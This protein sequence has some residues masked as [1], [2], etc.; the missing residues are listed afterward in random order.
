MIAHTKIRVASVQF[1]LRHTPE[2]QHFFDR[3][4]HFVRAAADYGAHFVC[5]PEHFTLQLLSGTEVMLSPAHAIAKLSG[6]RVPLRDHLA[7]LARGH[8]INIVGGSHATAME[9]GAIRNISMV[10]LRDGTVHERHKLHPTPDE[11]SVWEIGGGDSAEPIETEYGPIGVMICYDSE[12]PEMARALTDRGARLFFVPYC[13]DTR[14]GHLRVRYCCHA[15]TVE[16]QCYVVTS[17]LV[18]NVANVANLD[19]AYAQ[20]A[21][22]TPSDFGF[23]RD[24]IAVEATENAEMMVV[25]DLDMTALDAARARGSVRN[26]HDRRPELYEVSWRA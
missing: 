6:Y 7:S 21:I 2:P 23:A 25:A 5:F 9:G 11:K 1:A 3:V 20:S 12:F 24:G 17:G 10:A 15:R 26:L 8:S 4:A 13:T 19:M 18:G 22:L 16:N 14:H